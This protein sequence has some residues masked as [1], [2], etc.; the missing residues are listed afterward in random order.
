MLALLRGIG[1]EGG[2]PGL[3]VTH[4]PGAVAFVDR[5]YTL[6]DGRIS[7]GLDAELAPVSL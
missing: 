3:L 7:D 6:R 1:H 4:D 2:I 5:V